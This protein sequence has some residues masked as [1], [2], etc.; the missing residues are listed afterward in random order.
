MLKQNGGLHDRL[1]IGAVLL[2]AGEGR[3]MGGITKCL[4]RLEGVPLITRQLIAL[5]GA[6]IDEVVVVTGH[7]REAVEEQVQSFP[8]T[9]AY[10]ERYAAG[11]QGSVRVG[12]AALAGNFDAVL[13]LLAD[14]P[15]IGAGDLLELIGAF[16]KRPSGH[17]L[18]PFV[19][20]SRGNPVVIDDSVRSRIL[21]S[22]L[23]LGCREFIDRHPEIVQKHETAN[24]RFVID[25]DTVDDVTQLAQRTGWRLELP[26]TLTPAQGA[27]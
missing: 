23:K 13:I 24:Q 21:T 4:I 26:P 14:Q 18:I 22:E 16:K 2:A 3:R 25:L 15:L 8:V 5:S 10:N 27:N 12:L 17:V 19:G 1:R 7:G 20:S 6:G 9:L 11:Q